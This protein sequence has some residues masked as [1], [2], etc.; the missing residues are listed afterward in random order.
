MAMSFKNSMD[1]SELKKEKMK[2]V[3]PGVITHKDGTI[4]H[5]KP[6]QEEMECLLD[7]MGK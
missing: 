2:T 5:Y 4:E 1:P 7:I 6:S 3:V